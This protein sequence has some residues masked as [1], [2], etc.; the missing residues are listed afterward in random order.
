MTALAG[1]VV[2]VVVVG[3][4]DAIARPRKVVINGATLTRTERTELVRLLKAKVEP[5]RYWYDPVSGLWGVEGQPMHGQ[6]YPGLPVK[7]PLRVSAS[8]GGSGRVTGVFVNGREIHPMELRFLRRLF[9]RVIPGQYWLRPDGTYGMLYG[10]PLGN[11]RRATAQKYG[12]G[13]GSV[14]SPGLGA[15]PGLSVGRASDGCLYIS[16]GSYSSDSC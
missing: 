3:P 9:G 16:Y 6:I 13:G 14:Y 15:R 8:G 1:L 7:A 10:P 4:T 2:G 5:G 11:L 12:G